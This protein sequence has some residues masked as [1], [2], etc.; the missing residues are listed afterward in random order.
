MNEMMGARM[1]TS[2]KSTR[3]KRWNAYSDLKR[4]W[5]G[6]IVSLVR[7]GQMCRFDQPVLLEFRWFERN[8]RRDHDNVA[9]AK[10]LVLDAL[11]RAGVIGGDGWKHVSG[12]SDRFAVD[13]QRPGVLVRITETTTDERAA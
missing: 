11:V 12:F 3:G 4:Q 2:G 7:Q 10:K 6:T 1:R 5:E 8:R 13:P 9:A